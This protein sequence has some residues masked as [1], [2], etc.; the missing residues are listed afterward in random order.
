MPALAA[1]L[2]VEASLDLSDLF[3]GLA[4][5]VLGVDLGATAFDPSALLAR[6]AQVPHHTWGRDVVGTGDM[7]NSNSV[8]SWLLHTTGIDAAELGPPDG[9][10]APGWAAGITAAGPVVL[11]RNGT[12][13]SI[14]RTSALPG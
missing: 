10:A 2:E 3:G 12:P 5:S 4:A 6:V 9:G 14:T 13:G 8:I 7:W 1:Q 11:G